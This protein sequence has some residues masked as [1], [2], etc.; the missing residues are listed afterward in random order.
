MTL[1]HYRLD[2][3]D[4]DGTPTLSAVGER[5][6]RCHGY[7]VPIVTAQAM[8]SFV[9][10]WA[11]VD[12]NGTWGHVYV[13]DGALTVSRNDDDDT[14]SWERWAPASAEVLAAAGID[15]A[16]HGTLFAVDGWLFVRVTRC[17]FHHCD[18]PIHFVQASGEA[19]GVGRWTHDD[20]T[21]NYSPATG[22]GHG[23][24]NY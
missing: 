5:V 19:P 2:N 3:H 4:D 15:P 8:A 10:E 1:T 14:S 24:R 21:L 16:G 12:P 11:R 6:D 23:A 18:M 22:Y 20:A 9:D 13:M 17:G 7:A